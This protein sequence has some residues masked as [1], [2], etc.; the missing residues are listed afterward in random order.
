LIFVLLI[1]VIQEDASDYNDKAVHCFNFK[2][3]NCENLDEVKLN[4][5]RGSVE[6]MVVEEKEK[7]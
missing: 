2:Y 3:E 4:S 6:R 5:R 7:Y 1:Q